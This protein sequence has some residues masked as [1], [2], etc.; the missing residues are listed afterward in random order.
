MSPDGSSFTPLNLPRDHPIPHNT[1]YLTLHAPPNTDL[2]RKPPS[3]ETSTAPVLYTTLLHPFITANVTLT[4]DYELE[5]DQGGL[6]IFAGSPPSPPASTPTPTIPNTNPNAPPPYTLPQPHPSAWVKASL[7]YTCGLPH[8][9]SVSTTTIGSDISLSPL[10][11][12]TRSLRLKLERI[13]FA[14]WIWYSLPPPNQ[15]PPP[16]P[17]PPPYSP[18][19]PHSE[20]NNIEMSDGGGVGVEGRSQQRRRQRRNQNRNHEYEYDPPT[21]W[22]KLRE[23]TWF[24]WGVEDKSVRV[25]VYAAR[26][27]CFGISEFD[28]REG[29]QSGGGSGSGSGRG[30][31]LVEF[32]GLEIC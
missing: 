15:R 20:P 13:G 16:P 6:V 11:P 32:E 29:G 27:A 26:P 5:W 1:S 9:T 24:F 30:G 14:L 3:Q 23:V 7:E 8:V 12:H 2:H 10:P 22:K 17:P 28:R 31:L 19:S 21:T 4:L 18:Y 25:G